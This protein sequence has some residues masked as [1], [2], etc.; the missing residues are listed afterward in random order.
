MVAGAAVAQTAPE[1]AAL[2]ERYRSCPAAGHQAIF[3]LQPTF[4]IRF[5][6]PDSPEWTPSPQGLEE[7]LLDPTSWAAPESAKDRHIALRERVGRAMPV[8]SPQVLVFEASEHWISI[9]KSAIATR[10]ADGVWQ[11]DT[12]RVASGNPEVTIS[13][14]VLSPED[15]A[16]LD[17]LIADPCLGAEPVNTDYS[18]IQTSQGTRWILEVVEAPSS[19]IVAGGHSGFGRAGAIVWL[20]AKSF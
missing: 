20:V 19:V 6:S 18:S 17:A 11:L 16:R 9:E 12:V 1:Q 14:D 2:I 4:E 10:G 7:V 5:I 8:G 13:D 15:G 3:D